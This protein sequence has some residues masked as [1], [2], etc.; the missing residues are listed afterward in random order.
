MMLSPFAMVR[1]HFLVWWSDET[2]VE[3]NSYSNKFNLKKMNEL[4]DFEDIYISEIEH[5]EHPRIY[6]LHLFEQM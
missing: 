6:K 5:V 1:K 2:D 3:Y 4:H